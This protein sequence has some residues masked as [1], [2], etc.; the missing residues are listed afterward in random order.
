MTSKK[1]FPTLAR[2]A[3]GLPMLAILA[4]GG[5]D[6]TG[7]GGGS[8][9]NGGTTVPT[10]PTLSLDVQPIFTASCALAGCHTGTAPQEGLDLSAG[11]TFGNTVDIPSTQLPSMNRIT[12]GDPAQSYLVHKIEG[13]QAS[14]GGTGSRMPLGRAALSSTQIATI[15]A[16]ITSGAQNN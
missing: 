11:N 14:A 9:G 3:A 8:G 10:N 7:P 16:W 15:R 2:L 5:G 1:R 6:S 13:T 4:C 12:P